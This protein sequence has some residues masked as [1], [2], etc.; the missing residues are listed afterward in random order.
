MR[1]RSLLEDFVDEWNQTHKP[2]FEIMSET[3]AVATS[4]NKLWVAEDHAFEIELKE[5]QLGKTDYIT[6]L[7]EL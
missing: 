6:D 4:R 1:R 3:T 5:Y 2:Q 7:N